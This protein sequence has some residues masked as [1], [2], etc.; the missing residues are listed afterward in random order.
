MRLIAAIAPVLVLVGMLAACATQRVE[1]PPSAALQPVASSAAVAAGSLAPSAPPPPAAVV[2]QDARPVV[3]W[4]GESF[5]E[6][7]DG[8]LEHA[9]GSVWRRITAATTAY[10][11]S[12][13]R[14]VEPGVTAARTCARTTYGFAT[15]WRVLPAGTV[16]WVPG[17]GRHR[18]DDKCGAAQQD[19]S[20]RRVVR[21][22]LRIPNRGPV[23]EWRGD[24]ETIAIARRHG[25]QRGR[26]VLV[27]VD[28]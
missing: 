23:G 1:S 16:L 18:V 21:I 28:A 5:R 12:Y 14:S 13:I 17:Y 25:Y 2:V 4:Q 10:A 3:S 7:L 19:W 27:R 9:D 26:T 15:D 20:R 24:P 8:T 6:N 22:D 11:W